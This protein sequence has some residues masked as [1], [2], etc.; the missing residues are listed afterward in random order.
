MCESG[1][2]YDK[3]L[4]ELGAIPEVEQ[5]LLPITTDEG[6]A[7][8]LLGERED[9]EIEVTL[10]SGC[11]DHVLDSCDAPGYVIAESPRKPKQT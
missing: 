3:K 7:E 11:C 6:E 8:L 10:D 4:R 9:I 5:S 2:N 1:N